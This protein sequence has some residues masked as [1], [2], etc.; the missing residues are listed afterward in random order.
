LTGEGMLVLR[1]ASDDSIVDDILEN[2][3]AM[4]FTGSAG[5]LKGRK[6]FL[7]TGEYD[8]TVPSEPLDAFWD[9]IGDGDARFRRTYKA[10]HSMM[11]ARL[12]LS[13]DLKAFILE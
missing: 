9:A 2:A 6:V 11:G 3:S 1:R 8:T 12:S 5:A 4:R 13:D 10:G 7:A